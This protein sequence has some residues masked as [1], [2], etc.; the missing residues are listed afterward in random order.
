MITSPSGTAWIERRHRAQVD[1]GADETE[2]PSPF[3]H[4]DEPD[5]ELPL[6]AGELLDEARVSPRRGQRLDALPAPLATEVVVGDDDETEQRLRRGFGV[7]RRG[8]HRFEP[9]DV[10]GDLTRELVHVGGGEELGPVPEVRIDRAGRGAGP[11]RDLGDADAGL[12]PFGEEG[13]CR[14]EECPSRRSRISPVR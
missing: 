4:R 2:I 8:E 7:G 10:V 6:Q 3:E 14:V 9:V 13:E 1:V 11:A 5:V 12:A